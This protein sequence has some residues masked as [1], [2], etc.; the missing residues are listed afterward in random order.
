MCLI[1][2]LKEDIFQFIYM[3]ADKSILF[4]TI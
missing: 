4:G 1:V 3:L 2:F